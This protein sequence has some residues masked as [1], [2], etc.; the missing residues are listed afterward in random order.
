VVEAVKNLQAGDRL[1]LSRYN[2]NAVTVGGTEILRFSTGAA[3]KIQRFLD[4]GYVV[5]GI[6]AEYIVVWWKKEEDRPYRVVLPRLELQ[7]K[8]DGDRCLSGDFC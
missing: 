7:R 8:S 1:T 2:P 5:T 4:K 6:Y 3:E